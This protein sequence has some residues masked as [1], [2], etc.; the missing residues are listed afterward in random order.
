MCRNGLECSSRTYFTVG[1]A[2]TAFQWERSWFAST[3]P[4]TMHNKERKLLP[5]LAADEFSE[6]QMRLRLQRFP[7]PLV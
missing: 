6:L 4:F 7:D 3:L 2:F 5:A 1:T